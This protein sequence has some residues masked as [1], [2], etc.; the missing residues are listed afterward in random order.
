[1]EAVRGMY[2]S[3]RGN[4]RKVPAS[5]AIK[6]GM[7]PAGGLF[8]PAETPALS[9]EEILAMR[10][11]S[12]QGTAERIISLFLNDFTEEEIKGCI[13]RA[14]RD[15]NFDHP[16]VAPLY[17]LNEH[18]FF[19]ELWHGPTAA[20]KDIALQI[21]PH[22]LSLAVEKM[23][24]Q[25]EI[26]ILVATSGDTG[27][28]ALEG[29][30]NVPGTKIIVFYPYNG[31]SKIQELQMT[32]T[33]GSNTSA[34]AVRGNFDDCQNAVKDIFADED[35]NKILATNG[36]ELSSANSINWGRLLPQIVYYFRAYLDLLEQ[37]EIAPGEKIN[38]TVPTG[39]FGNILASWYAQRMGLPINKLICASNENKVLTDFFRSGIY[40]REREFKQTRS[41]SMDILI[42]SNLERFLFEITGHDAKKINRWMADLKETGRFEVD[43]ATKEAMDEIMACDYASEEETLSAIKEIYHAAEYIPDTH[44]AVGYKV[45]RKYLQRT[46][47]STRTVI[48]ATA[49]PYKFSGSVLEAIKGSSFIQGKGE[50]E[51]LEELSKINPVPLHFGLRDLDK[52]PVLHRTVCEQKEIREQIKTI[53]GVSN[54]GRA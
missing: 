23:G 28:A 11:S 1:M 2:I 5:E 4:F 49:S 34:I 17:R 3:T 47:D 42:S 44:T 48:D 53:L 41:P 14:Y 39:N 22:F 32:T 26:V 52:K 12:Y 10:G 45:Y 33:D 7:V 50:F 16:Q 6:L 38:F 13:A 24:V 21:M 9:T 20:F 46:G 27:K 37:E 29:F 18:T 19:L 40:D 30:K 43:P 15:D 35:F 8:V 25:R 31:V 51:I 36:Y 54:I